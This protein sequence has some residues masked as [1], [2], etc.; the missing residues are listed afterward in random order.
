MNVTP[1]F[2]IEVGETDGIVRCVVRGFWTSETADAY[3][4]ILDPILA[5]RRHR[6]GRVRALIDRR[7]STVQ[8][9]AVSQRM[10]V[11][12]RDM[13]AG[14][15]V[16]RVVGSALAAMQ[17]RRVFTHQGDR[18]FTTMDEAEDWLSRN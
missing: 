7:D 9:P 3:F 5:E 16:A 8:S 11:T 12:S 4:A 17:L 13:L 10:L 18:V 2:T 15:R 1:P 14:D 6:E